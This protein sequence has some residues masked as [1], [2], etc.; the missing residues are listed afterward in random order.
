VIDRRNFFQP[1]FVLSIAL[2]GHALQISNGFYNSRALAWIAVA[3]ACALAGAT[4]HSR[5]EARH[6]GRFVEVLLWVSIAW[7]LTQL[8]S[9]SPGVSEL[10]F[11]RMTGFQAGVALQAA[12][13]AAACARMRHVRGVWFPAVLILQLWLGA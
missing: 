11:S 10:E 8:L 4:T 7:Q 13:L 5:S 1:A 2:L 12:L 6:N 3:F 9:T